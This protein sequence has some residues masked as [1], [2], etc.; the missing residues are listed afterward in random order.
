MAEAKQLHVA[1]SSDRDETHAPN[2]DLDYLS[3][4]SSESNDISY[5]T[6]SEDHFGEVVSPTDND[7]NGVSS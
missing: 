5:F 6:L 1:S 2:G 3:V 7:E 4:A